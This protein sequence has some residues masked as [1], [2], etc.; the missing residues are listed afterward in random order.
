MSALSQPKTTESKTGTQSQ[1]EICLCAHKNKPRSQE[2]KSSVSRR[3]NR[4]IGQLGGIKIMVEDDRYCGDV[5]IQL[6]AVESAVKAISR[7]VMQ[8]HLKS[9]VVDRV[10]QGDTDVIDEVMDLFK[11]FM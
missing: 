8:D 11:K 7:E 4:V 5:L 10:Q 2:L 9:C 3:I 6:A 1:S